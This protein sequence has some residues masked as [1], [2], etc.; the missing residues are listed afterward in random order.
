[1][2]L[3]PKHP[4]YI[5]GVSLENARIYIVLMKQ[6]IRNGRLVLSTRPIFSKMVAVAQLLKLYKFSTVCCWAIKG[7]SICLG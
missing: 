5:V 2:K 7:N 3:D 1:M 4:M 6:N